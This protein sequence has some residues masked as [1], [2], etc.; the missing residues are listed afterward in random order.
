MT[1]GSSSAKRSG[2]VRIQPDIGPG[3]VGYPLLYFCPQSECVKQHTYRIFIGL[4]FELKEWM[5]CC[6]KPKPPL[7]LKDLACSVSNVMSTV[8]GRDADDKTTLAVHNPATGEQIGT[9]P[10]MGVAETKRAIE[11]ANAAW[12]AWRA[13]TAKERSIILR[14][15]FRSDDG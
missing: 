9:V 10:K 8:P 6:K 1:W 15:W 3:L 12:P 13:K 5:S 11:A 7:N 14:K 4:I 2:G